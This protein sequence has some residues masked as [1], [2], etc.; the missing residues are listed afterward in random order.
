MQYIAVITV[1]VCDINRACRTLKI[2]NVISDLATVLMMVACFSVCSFA[3]EPEVTGVRISSP[4]D[5]VKQFYF[6]Y[7]TAWNDTDVK[8]SLADSEKAVS[9]YT[10]QHL[11]SLMQYNDTGADYFIN[12]QEAC[13][14][15]AY[16]ISTKILDLKKT[17]RI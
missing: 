15:W 17:Q 4:E 5:T 13:R 7:L 6:A 12:A 1:F 10:T 3:Q 14:D 8:R 11:R 16:N 9:E 2:K